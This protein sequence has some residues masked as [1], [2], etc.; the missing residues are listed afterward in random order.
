LATSAR[1]VWA[2]SSLNIGGLAD[3]AAEEAAEGAEALEA[4]EKAALG[5]AQVR[6]P[7]QVLGPLDATTREICPR[8]LAVGHRESP[9]EVVFRIAGLPCHRVEIERF[10]V[11]AVD[12]VV[13][14][15]H[16][17]QGDGRDVWH[18]MSIGCHTAREPENTVPESGS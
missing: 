18:A 7:Q 16:G 15:A 17:G 11:I 12:E 9:G 14:S 5:D 3:E 2:S 10:R 13:R 6:G 4:D 1:K 8:G